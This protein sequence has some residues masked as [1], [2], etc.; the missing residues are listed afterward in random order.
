MPANQHGSNKGNKGKGDDPKPED[1]DSITGGTTG[2]HVEDTT[3]NENTTTRAVE[4]A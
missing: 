2:S 1:K 4:L 3:T